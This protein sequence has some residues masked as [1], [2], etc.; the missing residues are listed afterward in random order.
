MTSS[1]LAYLLLKKGF[2]ADLVAPA[3]DACAFTSAGASFVSV[4][5]D[6]ILFDD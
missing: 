2:A 3:I 4:S 5:D 6:F 1:K